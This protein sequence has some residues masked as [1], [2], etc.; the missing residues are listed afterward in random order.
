MRWLILGAGAQGR[1]TLDL[2][3]GASPRDELLFADDDPRRIGQRL[4]GIQIVSRREVAVDRDTTRVIVSIGHNLARL[5]LAED[6]AAAGWNFGNV[7]HPSAVVLRSATLGKGICLCPG[8]IIGSA[9]TVG[10]HVLVNTG[11]IVEHD[12]V[13]E[14][15]V[16][17]SPGVPRRSRPNSNSQ[18]YRPAFRP[19]R[20]TR[21][22]AEDP[23]R[24]RCR[25]GRA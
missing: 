10:D 25:G 19:A 15:G 6:T 8:A 2:L 13:I 16:S 21:C 12:C 22:P 7:I 5:R 11:A 3:R 23:R 1:I 14:P 24:S 17:L 9:A 4:A 20:Y 18:W